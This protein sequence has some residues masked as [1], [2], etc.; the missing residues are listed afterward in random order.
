[1][2]H[3]HNPSRTIWRIAVILGF[4]YWIGA[5][6]R[7]GVAFEELAGL[8]KP[9][10]VAIKGLFSL[11]LALSVLIARKGRASFLIGIALAISAFADMALVTIGT[12]AGGV[13]F[14]AAHG[15]AGYAYFITRRASNHWL[16]WTAAVAVPIVSVGASY[17]VLRN[18]DQPIVLALFPIVSGGMAT[19][20]ILSRFPLWLSGLG[21]AIFVLSDILF[22]AHIG[23]LQSS[24]SL[25]YL[26]WASYAIGYAMVAKGAVSLPSEHI[27]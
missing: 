13:G 18:T 12:V 17:L 10:I 9:L 24:G 25:G 19:L 21:A 27:H 5:L 8:P 1:M 6:A 2:N 11:L 15:F 16:R 4:V 7:S 22:L 3:A 26:T 23:I 20:A 14:A